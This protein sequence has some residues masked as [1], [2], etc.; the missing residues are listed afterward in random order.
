MSR[1]YYSHEVDLGRAV[2]QAELQQQLREEGE[3]ELVRGILQLMRQ[4]RAEYQAD[5]HDL[6]AEDKD[7]SAKLKMGAAQALEHLFWQI[8][9]DTPL[10]QELE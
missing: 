5:A 9:R 7:N 4:L 2:A 6:L 10:V 1:E 3:G 8:A